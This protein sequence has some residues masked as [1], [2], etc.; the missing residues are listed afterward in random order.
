MKFITRPFAFIAAITVGAMLLAAAVVSASMLV[1]PP[2]GVSV[3]IK[4]EGI[5][6]WVPVPSAWVSAGM[7]S[8]PLESW[9]DLGDEERRALAAAAEILE[10]IEDADDATLV[11]VDTDAE[12]VRVIKQGRRMIVRVRS[13]EADVD[14][15][16]PTSLLTRVAR[17]LHSEPKTPWTL[18]RG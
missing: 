3:N 18:W 12:T 15:Q 10:R 9:V 6:F 7:N 8:I 16:M 14:V 2:I 11:A 4:S 1:A 17:R 5:K 13:E